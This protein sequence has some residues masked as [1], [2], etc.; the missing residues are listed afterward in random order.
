MARSTTQTLRDR[1]RL[2]V[3]DPAG[4]DQRL[5]EDDLEA[6]LDARTCCY[7]AAP[8]WPGIACG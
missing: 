1:L 3:N 6:L 7:S 5:S 8:A 2:M 4:A